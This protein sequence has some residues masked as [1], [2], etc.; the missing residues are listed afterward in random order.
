VSF[1]FDE[2]LPAL[3]LLR[4]PLPDTDKPEK[5]TIKIIPKKK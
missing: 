3:P 1:T 5:A 2:K 4:E